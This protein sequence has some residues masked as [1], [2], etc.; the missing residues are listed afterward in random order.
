MFAEAG[1]RTFLKARAMY[2]GSQAHPTTFYS[3]SY[4]YGAYTLAVLNS[5][6]G[7][8]VFAPEVRSATSAADFARRSQLMLFGGVAS[9]DGWSSGFVPW[10]SSVV[11]PE[12]EAMFAALAQERAR[13]ATFLLSAY[14]RQ[15]RSTYR[16]L[17][18]C[19]RVVY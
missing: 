12:V 1:R 11:T 16:A 10:N 17:G 7:G 6:W 15:G 8:W 9:M 18:W 3:D 4:D 14:A 13:L 19:T 2:V 5:G